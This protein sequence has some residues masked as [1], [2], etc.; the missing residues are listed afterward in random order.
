M[1]NIIKSFYFFILIM[2]AACSDSSDTADCVGDACVDPAQQLAI[3]NVLAV[4]NP[5]NSLSY[6]IEWT[7]E[8]AA[9]TEVE[10]T[11]DDGINEIYSQ[12]DEVL[13]HSVLA[14]MLRAGKHC[15]YTLRSVAGQ[16]VGEVSGTFTVGDAP[17][18]LPSFAMSGASDAAV[19]PGYTFLNLT[20]A[21]A[22]EELPLSVI[23]IDS[24]GDIRWYHRRDTTSPG[25]ATD[26]VVQDDGVLIAGPRN[27]PAAKVDWD[28]SIR[29]QSSLFAHHH[30]EDMGD[31]T[32]I[33]PRSVQCVVGDDNTWSDE[34]VRWEQST[35]T[36][37]WSM[38][39][40]DVFTPLN[41]YSDWSHVNAI[42]VFPDGESLLLCV[43]DQNSLFK[44][45]MTT[46]SIEWIM[47]YWD[48]SDGVLSTDQSERFDLTANAGISFIRVSEEFSRQHSASLLANGNILLFDNGFEPGNITMA[49]IPSTRPYSRAIEINY[50]EDT[51]MASIIWEQR[52]E[53]DI[54]AEVWSDVDRLPNS[55]S[56]ITFGLQHFSGESSVLLEVD[57]D[58]AELWR[59]TVQQGW[60]IYRSQRRVVPH[61]V[62]M[63]N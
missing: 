27:V 24:A 12:S 49:P 52:S 62:A 25:E 19:E 26:V 28:G 16:K 57:S 29:W 53:P 38:R 10:L 34:I 18:W 6:R 42:A 35:G 61:L 31:G 11:C 33:F 9:S 36:E 40:C 30:I 39:L 43:R 50:S 47:S 54:F 32:Y 7:S 13:S 55:N 2:V 37:L 21:K 46:S 17:S 15:E 51:G 14:M 45:N 41:Y 22:G 5:L 20:M 4:E 63:P 3:S 59:A 1:K 44:V 60:G 8:I 56:L 48:D 23:A 58:G